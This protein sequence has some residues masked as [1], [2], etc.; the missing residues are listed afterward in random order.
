MSVRKKMPAGEGHNQ[1][2]EPHAKPGKGG[3]GTGEAKRVEGG[4]LFNNGGSMKY[5]LVLLAGCAAPVA[6]FDA[7]KYESSCARQCLNANSACMSGSASGG[8]TSMQN[9]QIG[10][11]HA[12]AKQCL[13]TCPAK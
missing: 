9:N 10:A 7:S 1:R 4:N 5:L 2:A 3:G 12:N 13:A 8:S 6:D 11:C